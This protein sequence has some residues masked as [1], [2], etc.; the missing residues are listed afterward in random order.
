MYLLDIKSHKLHRITKTN[1]D[2]TFPFKL[3]SGTCT[4]DVTFMGISGV[5]KFHFTSDSAQASHIA[6]EHLDY[7]HTTDNFL[8]GRAF[9][10]HDRH[11]QVVELP[12]PREP[13]FTNYYNPTR[14]SHLVGGGLVRCRRSYYPT[15]MRSMRT[16][17]LEQSPAY[18]SRRA[19]SASRMPNRVSSHWRSQ[20]LSQPRS[21][22]S[23][24]SQGSRRRSRERSTSPFGDNTLKVYPGRRDSGSPSNNRGRS[25]SPSPPGKKYPDPIW[26]RQMRTMPVEHSKFIWNIVSYISNL[27]AFFDFAIGCGIPS[28]IV[29]SAIKDNDPSDDDISL[30]DCVVQALTVWWLSSNRPAIWK[31]ERIR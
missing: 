27:Q 22:I 7:D 11:P 28:H 23:V 9:T 2:S 8:L 15:E 31:S 6:W 19:C 29:R 17:G 12:P 4:A 5:H 20:S 18:F 3:P 25:R 30:E 16:I 21:I 1:K 14:P 26:K 13:G 10:H 24:D